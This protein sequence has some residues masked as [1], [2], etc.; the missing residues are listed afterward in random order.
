LASNPYAGGV[1]AHFLRIIVKKSYWLTD[2]MS[3]YL[4]DTMSYRNPRTLSE[5]AT[6]NYKGDIREFKPTTTWDM[7]DEDRAEVAL[8][9]E[10][11]GRSSQSGCGLKGL[12]V[13]FSP[14]HGGEDERLGELLIPRC[15][16]W[17]IPSK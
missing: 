5:T 12:I 14:K 13:A 8:R 10:G 6:R 1:L 15:A 7:E 3:L 11:I 2:D 16:E 9:R 4:G 17:V